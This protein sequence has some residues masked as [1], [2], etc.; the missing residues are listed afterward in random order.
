MPYASAWDISRRLK[1]A[2]T[3][4]VR[5]DLSPVGCLGGLPGLRRIAFHHRDAISHE[6]SKGFIICGQRPLPVTVGV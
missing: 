4:S 6:L 3:F 2:D 1:S 5:V